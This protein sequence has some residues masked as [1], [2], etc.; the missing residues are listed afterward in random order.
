MAAKTLQSVARIRR[1]ETADRLVRL[2]FHPNRSKG[3][4]GVSMA[5]EVR[6]VPRPRFTLDV[7]GTQLTDPDEV[8]RAQERFTAALEAAA[9]N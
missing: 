7:A 1:A 4:R 5:V 2:N 9:E 8:R 6:P 3:W